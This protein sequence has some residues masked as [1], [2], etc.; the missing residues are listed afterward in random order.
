MNRNLEE[1]EGDTA[2]KGII[3]K[4]AEMERDL[5]SLRAELVAERRRNKSPPI[6]P[7]K[8]KDVLVELKRLRDVLLSD[9]G[10]AAPST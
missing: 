10:T 3:R 9:V 8:E 1:M 6:T 2:I 7:V 5:E 4:V